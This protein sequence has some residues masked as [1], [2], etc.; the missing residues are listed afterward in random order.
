VLLSAAALADPTQYTLE[1]ANG[2]TYVVRDHRGRPHTY[3]GK[4]PCPGIRS[5]H[6]VVFDRGGPNVTCISAKLRDLVT[7]ATCSVWC[8][9]PSEPKL[10]PRPPERSATPGERK[11]DL[12]DL[13]REDAGT[14]AP[15]RQRRKP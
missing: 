11:T 9:N 15:E 13:T 6:K 14:R 4:R 3:R 7:N 2:K 12:L 8:V 10:L 5:G 1:S